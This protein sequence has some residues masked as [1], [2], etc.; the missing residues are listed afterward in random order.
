VNDLSFL[1]CEIKKQAAKPDIIKLMKHFSSNK[2]D[3]L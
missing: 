1:K 2:N 3:S